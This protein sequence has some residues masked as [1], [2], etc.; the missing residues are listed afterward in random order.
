MRTSSIAL[1]LCLSAG[2]PACAVSDPDSSPGGT[3]GPWE[4]AKTTT[5]DES[6]II[7]Q[8]T[9]R[10]GGLL[11]SGQVCRPVGTGPFPM[12]VAN[13]DGFSGL[14]AWN[15]GACAE[16][17]HAGYIQI[18]SSYR[19]QDGSDGVVELCLGE[20]DDTLR[21]LEIALELPEV[22]AS[23]VAMW[24]TGHGGCVTMRALQRGAPVKV[25]ASMY[26][27]TSMAKAYQFWRTQLETSAGPSG[28]YQRLIELANANIGGAPE[29][30]P[31]EYQLRSPIDQAAPLPT[32]VPFLLAHGVEDPL[33]SPR[34]SCELAQ[35]MG[36]AGHHFNEQHQLVTT[37]PV[38]CESAWTSSSS[39][40]ASWTGMRYLL[41]YDGSP[42]NVMDTDVESFL[43]AKLR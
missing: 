8:V 42:A 16:A 6:I 41:V 2:L 31:E 37:T 35:R 26:G 24:G 18:E 9:Y 32:N 22:D 3:D 17:A 39:Q 38:G 23:R 40:L 19:G 43:A 14:S 34:Q 12:I 25:A 20:V 1:A 29:A 11:V 36:V 5:D 13:H 21:M 10:S 4:S 30:Y 27:I 33:V 28:Q 15:G 7:Q